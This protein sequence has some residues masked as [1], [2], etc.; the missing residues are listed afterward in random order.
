MENDK[1]INKRT[2]NARRST[3]DDKDSETQESPIKKQR[4]VVFRDDVKNEN[5]DN[6]ISNGD[7][8][9]VDRTSTLNNKRT[10]LG[11]T[12]KNYEM[13]ASVSLKT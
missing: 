12:I 7:E 10:V 9:T 13:N 8:A 4:T 3:V 11:F 2:I 5:N 1:T 6:N